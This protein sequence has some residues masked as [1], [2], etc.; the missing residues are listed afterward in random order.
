MS[1]S[2]SASTPIPTA[3]VWHERYAWHWSGLESHAP[4]VQP[5]LSN[6]S[7]EGKRRI[8]NLI[9]IAP[10]LSDHLT[11]V[12]PRAATD[13]E[14]LRIHT[15]RYLESV[16]AISAQPAGGMIGHEL[17]IGAGGFEIAAIS[18]GGVLK[19]VEDVLAGRYTRAY[20]LVRP[21]GHHAE[22]D[23]GH[24]F[25]CFNNVGIAA[26]HALSSLGLKRVAVVD[27][28]VHHGNGTESQ[29][30]GRKD[31]L[32]ISLH[33]DRLYPLNTGDV[34][35][36]GE[37]EG[38]GYNFNIPL[39]PGSGIGAYRHA[40]ETVVLPALRAYKPELILVSSGFDGSFLDPLGRMLLTSDDFGSM[41]RMV[42][43]AADE[44][45][46]GRVVVAHEGGYSEVYSPFCCLRVCE[47]LSG[48][49]S[50]VHD[51]FIADVGSPAWV[52]LQPHQEAAIAK[53]R[54]NL[55]IALVAGEGVK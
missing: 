3:F 43:E 40:F 37:G 33:Q 34:T 28:D 1:S 20:A 16:K 35:D 19:A 49:R 4:F 22:A 53:A 15:P 30:Y 55:A 18:A 6:E 24:G 26:A 5:H 51:P 32:F 36:V 38:R 10:S 45:C 50:G 46:G 41:A 31:L 11:F 54:E 17:N 7:S 13:E 52:G 12:K 48:V 2:N 39:P 27:W 29:F 44:L 14:I 8:F 21:P 23:K 47:A 25:C 42:C 9:S